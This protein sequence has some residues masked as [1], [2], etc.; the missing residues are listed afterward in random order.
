M[1]KESEAGE[2]VKMLRSISKSLKTRRA[3]GVEMSE[4]MAGMA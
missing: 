1:Y 4:R 2:G 3:E